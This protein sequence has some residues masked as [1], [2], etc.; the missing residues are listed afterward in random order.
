MKK[1]RKYDSYED[2]V[3]FQKEKTTDPTRREK[4]LGEEWE[5]KLKGF[6]DIF[7]SHPQI[8]STGAKCLCLGARTGQEV[9]A[10]TNIGVDATGIDLVPCLPNV[11]EGDIHNL[12]S[13]DSQYDIV[14]SNILDH[15]LDIKK[16][17]EEATRVVRVG[18]LLH[19]QLQV[20]IH[21]DEYTETYF[22][23]PVRDLSSVMPLNT[24]CLSAQM[25]PQNFAGMNYQLIF[26]KTRE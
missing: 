19:F 23:D 22:D 12:K 3:T 15:A 7:R 11:I 6:E 1:A 17:M 18:G 8:Y 16:M 24:F 9:V 2:Y 10:L 26:Q 14:F 4:W 13:K 25:I 20:F 21:Q 5:M